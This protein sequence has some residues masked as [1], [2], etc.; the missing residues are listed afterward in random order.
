M[1]WL[2]TNLEVSS[3]YVKYNTTIEA[4]Y[5]FSG[6][7]FLSNDGPVTEQHIHTDY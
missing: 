1:K 6:H 3:D 5:E 4:T 2:D 7:N